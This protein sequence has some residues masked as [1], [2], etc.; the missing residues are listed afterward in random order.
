MNI[1]NYIG[2]YFA[3]ATEIQNPELSTW[4]KWYKGFDKTFHEYSVYNG[5]KKVK[6]KKKT[7][8]MA[9]KSCEDWANLLLNEKCEITI[10][11]QDKLNDILEYN[12]FKVEANNLVEQSFALSMGAIVESLENVTYNEETGEIVKT[13]DSRV[14]IDYVDATKIYPITFKNKKLIECAFVSENTN[15]VAISIHKLNENKEYDI[16]NLFIETDAKGGATGNEREFIFHSESKT[17]LFQII[18]PNICNNR[19]IGSP[20]GISVYAN[21]ID[22]LKA[23]DNAYDSF[24]NEIQSGRK[25]IMV[26]DRYAAFNKDGEM[27]DA[28]DPN[29]ALFYRLPAREGDE[30]KPFVE[31]VS[32]SLRTNEIGTALQEQ[33]NTYAASVG[34]GKNYYTFGGGGGRPIQTATGIIAQNSDLFRNLRKHE[35]LLE[36]VIKDMVEA[37]AYLSNAFTINKI[38]ASDVKVMF[39]DSIIED[40]ESK[41]NSDRTDVTNGIMSKQE[42]RAKWYAETEDIAKEKLD[43][44]GLNDLDTRINAL[45]PALQS[46]AITP[47]LFVEAVYKDKDNKEEIAQYIEEQLTKTNEPINFN[48]IA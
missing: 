38:D 41:K 42:Y 15:E 3:G 47:T 46:G 2:R 13:S 34:F 26:D 17:P 24:D 4:L 1:K 10:K 48:E 37:I 9:K 33:L 39:D 23:I 30:T 29:D 14:K 44:F 32:G 45:L 6:L 21:S 20:L 7:L 12:S 28:F 35:L 31:D 40:T 19:D 36:K 27:I 25:R 16:I 18:K 11:D 22:T 8:N 43:S 5:T